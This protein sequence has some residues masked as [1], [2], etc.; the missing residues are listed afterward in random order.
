MDNDEIKELI[1]NGES[2]I[3]IKKKAL[4]LGYEPIVVDG[5]RKVLSGITNME[6]LNRKL[7]IM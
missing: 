5:I 3:A 7:L 1:S 6:E 2:P 4:K